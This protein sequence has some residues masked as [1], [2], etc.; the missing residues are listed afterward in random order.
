V[1]DTASTFDPTAIG[2]VPAGHPI[3]AAVVEDPG[4][5]GFILT[6]R[7]SLSTHPWLADHAVVGTAL[8]PGAGF[9]ELAMRAAR[10]ARAE[11]IAELTLQAPL[12][13]PEQGGVGLRVSVSGLDDEDR[14]EIAIHSRAEEEGAEWVLHAVGSLTPDSLPQPAP[15]LE[16]PWPPERAEP[17]E[18]DYG[19]IAECGYEFG[20]A[21]QGVTA[22]WRHGEYVYSEVSQAV[23][24]RRDASRFLLHPALLD[25][26]LHGALLS[27]L[28]AD[29]GVA[30][31]LPFAWKGVQVREAAASKLRTRIERCEGGEEISLCAFDWEGE[32]VFRCESLSLRPFDPATLGLSGRVSDDLPV[33]GWGEVEL[34][35]AEERE[36]VV[37]HVQSELGA[38]SDPAVA[39]RAATAALLERLRAWLA[40]EP[41]AD[42]RLAVVT[43][44]A[45]AVDRS[46]CPEPAQASL[47]GLARSAQSEHPDRILLIDSDGTAASKEALPA[48]LAAG[49]PQLALREGRALAPRVAGREPGRG[50]LLPPPPPWR[51]DVSRR[52]SLDGLALLPNPEAAKPLGPT[53]V[54]IEM[55][56]AGLN[57]RD[58]M[59][60]LGHYPGEATIGG[61]GAGVVAEVGTEV[62]DLLP[63]DR[64]MGMIPA[65]FAPLAVA[66]RRLL[67]PIPAGWSFERAAAT[68]IACMTAYRGLFDLAALKE[69]ERVLVHAGAGGVGMAAIQLARHAGAE[70]FATAS[71]AKWGALE[72]LG[73]EQGHIA[74][75]RELSFKE[76]FLDATDGEGV[77][78]V[79]NSLA[80][81]FVEASLDLLPRGGRFVEMGKTDVR[82]PARVAA[83]RPGVSYR[84]FDLGEAG[85][86]RLAELLAE[87]PPLFETGA[88]R[89]PPIAIWDVRE[90]PAAFRHLR[91]GANVGKVVL[92]IPRPLDPERTVLITGAT[93][94]L[95]A[96]LARHLVERHGARQLL[97]ASR[98]GPKAPGAAELRER[99][100]ALGASVEIAACDVS[101]R[102][103][104]Q[105]LLGQVP[106][107]HPLGAVFHAA[108]ALADATIAAM[109]PEQLERP[110]APKAQGAWN[111]HE[112][113]AG[114]ELSHFVLFSSAAGILGS[115]GQGGYAAANAFLDALAQRRHAEGLPATSIAWGLWQRPT[116]MTSHLGEADL[117][118]MG[119]MGL[120]PLSDEQG[121]ALLDR[122]LGAAEPLLLAGLAGVPAR[123]E[124]APASIAERL[125]ALAP[126]EREAEL[127]ALVRAEAAGVLGHASPEEVAPDSAFKDLGLDS[128]AAVELRNRL[129]LITGLKLATIAIFDFATPAAL[130]KHLL[131][132]IGGEEEE[133]RLDAELRRFE[134]AIAALPAGRPESLKLAAYLRARAAD[135]ESSSREESDDSAKASRLASA[136]DE[137]LLDF[138]DE[139]VRG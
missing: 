122:A 10:E 123:R 65:A 52:G 7:L 41:R 92:E 76:K 2:Q 113:T 27:S 17:L 15:S 67:A 56:A 20:P 116:G 134:T 19:R 77:D 61:E 124:S 80:G 132:Q 26:A 47:W 34:G 137:E 129:N 48:A 81:E 89:H 103:Q 72:E 84:A 39:A 135:L 82:D 90:A 79:L 98:S 16:G 95:G 63:G 91:E 125:A 24:Q 32:V 43:E 106:D 13:L 57:F 12:P 38:D 70:V 31:R 66:E 71:P 131:G 94:G 88:L 126:A 45:V 14:R 42:A 62:D 99:L 128:L 115:P 5:G 112:L 78:V 93:G 37:W 136:S 118:R 75:S 30:P 33:L 117:A 69:G 36:D 73:L 11:Q 21:F 74:S 49:E 111:L 101:D 29:D 139:Q 119:R 96:P 55:R 114:A 105:G 102:A 6:G 28:D 86:E 18:V 83:E 54:R 22:A 133:T 8:F 87:L 120:A 85:P 138:I 44:N 127:L 1:E 121:L 46:D 4:E 40:A 23:A 97:L 25:A 59:V 107:A 100:E 3:L 35:G 51:L 60:A 68:P 108:G 64:A 9:L 50:T 130:A 109:A 104:L 53:E 110:F 58:V